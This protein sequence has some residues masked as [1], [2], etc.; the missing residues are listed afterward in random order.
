MKKVIKNYSVG[1]FLVLACVLPYVV[2]LFLPFYTAEN[3]SVISLGFN[4]YGLVAAGLMILPSVI[5]IIV[6]LAPTDVIKK[7]VACTFMSLW[8]SGGALLC[9]LLLKTKFRGLEISFGAILAICSAI[10]ALIASVI[11]NIRADASPRHKEH[12]WYTEMNKIIL[13]VNLPLLTCTTVLMVIFHKLLFGFDFLITAAIFAYW[14]CKLFCSMASLEALYSRKKYGILYYP[15]AFLSVFVVFVFTYSA[16]AASVLL[17]TGLIVSVICA[18]FWYT[19][20]AI[21]KK[22]LK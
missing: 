5:T 10:A 3:S 8:L 6:L 20:G 18:V 12:V 9:S 15:V 2:S 22:S 1:S 11:A 19:L 21:A 7:Y 16:G 14:I 13:L 4:A 17:I